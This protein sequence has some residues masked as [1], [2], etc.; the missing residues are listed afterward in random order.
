MSTSNRFLL[1][2]LS[3][4][5]VI[6][7]VQSMRCYFCNTEVE[8][9]SCNDPVDINNIQVQDCSNL[10]TTNALPVLQNL[11][12]NSNNEVAE[13]ICIIL[14]YTYYSRNVTSRGCELKERSLNGLEADVCAFYRS[15]RPSYLTNFECS[16]CNKDLCNIS[17]LSVPNNTSTLLLLSLKSILYHSQEGNKHELFFNQLSG[18]HEGI[19]VLGL[20]RPQQKNAFGVNLVNLLKDALDKIRHENICRVLILRSMVP[21][22]FCAGADLK[23]RAQM[24][25]KEVANFVTNLRTVISKL[26]EIPIPVLAAIDG[27]ALGGGLEICLACDIRVAASSAKMGLVE[28]KLAIIPGAGGTQR[29]PRLINPAV[30]KELIY[31]AKIIDAKRAYDIGLV[32]YV[33]EQDEGDAAF[34]KCLGIAEDILPNGPLAIQVAKKAINKGIEVDLDTGLTIEEACYAQIIPTK[35]RVEALKAFKEKRKPIFEGL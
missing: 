6:A 26:Q 25:T 18:E 4:L 20:N 15:I 11:V 30:A 24:N 19:I 10:E 17:P 3:I 28:T 35:D 14:S 9:Q 23:E 5:T 12:N 1:S 13:K 32:N 8:G 16:T 33:V 27:V 29:L 22:I 31:T 2:L 34:K 21:K 7:A